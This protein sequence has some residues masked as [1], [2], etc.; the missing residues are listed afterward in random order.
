M[1]T[2]GKLLRDVLIMNMDRQLEDISESMYKKK[3]SE[4]QAEQ[5]YIVVVCMMKGLLDTFIRNTGKKKFYYISSA[6]A[7]GSF[8]ENHLINLGIYE[9]LEGVLL[10]KGQ[11]MAK[12]RA[13]EEEYIGKANSFE[14]TSRCFFEE[15]KKHGLPSEAMGIRHIRSYEDGD[16]KNDTYDAKKSWLEKKDLHYEIVF[17]HVKAGIDCYHMDVVGKDK[18]LY[19]FHLY[20]LEINSEISKSEKE[21]YYE[22]FLISSSVRQIL[23]EMRSNQYD[24][25]R[26][27]DY[28]KIGV[29]GKY[30]AFVIAELIRIMVDEKAIPMDESLEVVRKVCGYENFSQM[31]GDVKQCSAEYVDKLVPQ[32]VD[33]LENMKK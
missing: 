8:L 17:N 25:R 11:S 7:K 28:V 23:A 15:C 24:L 27:D 6:F 5:I 30:A 29:E 26:M 2:Q 9:N 4:L 31:I 1:L 10:S 13:V 16:E 3:I 14:N 12:I 21:I 33:K 32:L 22:Y 19:K 20:D 18:E